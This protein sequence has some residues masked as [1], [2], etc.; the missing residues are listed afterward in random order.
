MSEH[1]TQASFVNWCQWNEMRYPMLM[2]AFAIPNGAH[3]AGD[4]RTRAIKMARLKAEGFKPGVP[5][6]CLPYPC[7]GYNGL[8]IEFKHGKNSLSQYQTDYIVLLEQ[9]KHCVKVCY[10]VDEAIR[11]VEEYFNPI[12]QMVTYP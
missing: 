9:Y 5:D 4:A 2:M 8:W 10:T 12:H 1:D 3:L 6:W 7:G 11:A